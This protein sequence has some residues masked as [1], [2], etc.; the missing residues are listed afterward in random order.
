[1]SV[2]AP[3]ILAKTPEEYEAQIGRLHGFVERVH[4]DVTDGEFAAN[5]TVPETQVW[6]P[7]E[8]KADIH[9]MVKRPSEHLATI[10]QM[11]PNMVI[12]HAECEEDLAP[13]FKKLKEETMIKPAIALLRSTVPETCAE[14]IKEAEHVLIFSGNLGE[15]GGRASTMQLEK[16]RLVKA[17]NSNVEI[18][19]DGGAN[20]SNVFNLSQ[21]GVDVINVGGAIAES[22]DPEYTYRAMIEEI[23]RKGAI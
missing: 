5:L 12:F 4:I 7:K 2:I 23:N 13:I 18:G 9:M 16:I 3:A 6:W 1:M 21:S 22:E 11:N 20:L 14:A 10:I 17:I 8:W 15:Y 19:W